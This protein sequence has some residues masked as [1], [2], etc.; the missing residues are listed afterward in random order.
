VTDTL[1]YNRSWRW[2]AVHAWYETEHNTCDCINQL[3]KNIWHSERSVMWEL[4][5]LATLWAN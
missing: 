5:P 4:V 2:S 3:Q 1:W